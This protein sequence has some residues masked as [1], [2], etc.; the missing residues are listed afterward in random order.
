MEV[1]E[2]VNYLKRHVLLVLQSL[3]KLKQ[4]V[5]L[6]NKRIKRIVKTLRF[7]SIYIDASIFINKRRIIIGL[8]MDNLLIFVKNE[9]EI[10]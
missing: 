10:I 7:D 8:Y 4:L 2:R 9:S 3:Y 6:W 1:L 5:N